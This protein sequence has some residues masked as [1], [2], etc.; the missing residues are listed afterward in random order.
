MKKL[1]LLASLLIVG[2]SCSSD[3]GNPEK[4]VDPIFE[5]EYVPLNDFSDVQSNYIYAGAKIGDRP[6]GLISKNNCVSGNSITFYAT[7]STAVTR[8]SIF[9]LSNKFNEEL[10]VGC[11][12]DFSRTMRDVR[13]V[14]KGK[15]HVDIADFIW[16]EVRV[17]YD[18][19]G[20]QRD[21]IRIDIEKKGYYNGNLEIGFQGK[22]LRIEDKVSKYSGKD[23]VYLYFKRI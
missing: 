13:M 19:L 10:G 5:L 4:P 16:K 1:W 3:D 14:E 17:P 18:S 15:M 8:D 7:S 21:S 6:V 23:K 20:H 11:E 9:Y 22:Y 12:Y 2:A